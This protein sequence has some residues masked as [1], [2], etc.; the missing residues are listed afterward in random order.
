M[1]GTCEEAFLLREEGDKALSFLCYDELT[2][3]KRDAHGVTVG[4]GSVCEVWHLDFKAQK[5]TLVKVY[6]PR[7]KGEEEEIVEYV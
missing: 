7:P 2:V 3:A 4:H 1:E 5:M 6:K